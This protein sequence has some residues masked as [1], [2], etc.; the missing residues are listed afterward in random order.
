[1]RFPNRRNRSR[2]ELS[3]DDRDIARDRLIV[4]VLRERVYPAPVHLPVSAEM[5]RWDQL[6]Q[7]RSRL[8]SI[9][10]REQEA[11]IARLSRISRRCLALF[12]RRGLL[13]LQLS[14]RVRAGSTYRRRIRAVTNGD[15]R[16]RADKREASRVVAQAREDLS[17]GIALIAASLPAGIVEGARLPRFDRPC[18]ASRGLRIRGH[19]RDLGVGGHSALDNRRCKARVDVRT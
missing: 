8:R 7:G 3:A 19:S 18:G 17:N 2:R 11:R 12:V 16:A 13:L 6:V 10:S 5:P 4:P 15:W 9:N 14:R 1:M